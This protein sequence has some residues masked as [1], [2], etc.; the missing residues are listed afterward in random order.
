MIIMCNPSQLLPSVFHE[1]DSSWEKLLIIV[2]IQSALAPSE[3]SVS[4]REWDGHGLMLIF[5]CI[6]DR[7]K[8]RNK[9][10]VSP[11]ARLAFVWSAKALLWRRNADVHISFLLHL[12]FRLLLLLLLYTVWHHLNQQTRQ[13]KKKKKKFC[14]KVCITQEPSTLL[15]LLEAL[16]IVVLWKFVSLLVLP[17]HFFLAYTTVCC[18]GRCTCVN[19]AVCNNE[20]MACCDNLRFQQNW[21]CNQ[22][23]FFD[24]MIV[25]TE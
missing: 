5:H 21:Q 12:R 15:L 8:R 7:R 24:D 3:M 4:L 20:L 10:K 16:V 18:F 11:R 25:A 13:V 2:N 1:I 17:C 14:R 6:F 22:R 23:P 9:A 19:A